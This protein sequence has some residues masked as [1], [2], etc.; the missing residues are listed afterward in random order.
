MYVCVLGT[1]VIDARPRSKSKATL[2]Q[3]MTGAIVGP[4]VGRG[5]GARF[6]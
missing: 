3:S 4:V 6:L 2:T 1:S 5:S